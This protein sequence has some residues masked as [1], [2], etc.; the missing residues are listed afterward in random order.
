MISPPAKRKGKS[1]ADKDDDEAGDGVAKYKVDDRVE[2]DVEG[3][4]TFLPC[5]VS[6]I[7]DNSTYD[8]EFIGTLLTC[9]EYH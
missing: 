2:C 7:N 3:N 8:L 4:G 9:K 5:I 6:R 1:K